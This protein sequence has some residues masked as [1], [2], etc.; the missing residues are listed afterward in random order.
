MHLS[1]IFPVIELNIKIFYPEFIRDVDRKSNVNYDAPVSI[2]MR[3]GTCASPITIFQL[4]QFI[5][6]VIVITRLRFSKFAFS[7]AV[8]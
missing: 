2:Q 4:C 1:N 7:K 5:P 8:F 3:D 6:C